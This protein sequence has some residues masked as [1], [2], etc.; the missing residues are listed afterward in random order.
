MYLISFT[1][2]G[3]IPMMTVPML[4]QFLVAA[5]TY[6]VT[7]VPVGGPVAGVLAVV[8]KLLGFFAIAMPAASHAT[9]AAP[10]SHP[11]LA[12]LVASL[13]PAPYEASAVKAWAQSLAPT[14]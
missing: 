13:P 6:I 1:S 10:A 5:L 14:K 8:L 4:V 12:K 7:L 11:E 3:L 2:L 9:A